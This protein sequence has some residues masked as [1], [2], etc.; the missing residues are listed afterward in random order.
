MSKDVSS[1]SLASL[2][3]DGYYVQKAI[4]GDVKATAYKAIK[5]LYIGF[6][7]NPE[8]KDNKKE[9]I[10]Q[11]LECMEDISETA[12]KIHIEAVKQVLAEM[13]PP[14]KKKG[15]FGSLFS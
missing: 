15:L 1:E 9:A 10:I 6:D 7:D 3:Y 11:V 13:E 4:G 14:P 5:G 8:W 2:L 12:T